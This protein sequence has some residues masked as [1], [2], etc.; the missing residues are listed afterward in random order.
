[1]GAQNKQQS[2]TETVLEHGCGMASSGVTHVIERRSAAA[3]AVTTM[4]TRSKP[5]CGGR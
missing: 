5:Y 3:A 1:M 4:P 2:V